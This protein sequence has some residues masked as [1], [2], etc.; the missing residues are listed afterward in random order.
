VQQSGTVILLHLLKHGNPAFRYHSNEGRTETGL[1]NSAMN[2]NRILSID[3][4]RSGTSRADVEIRPGNGTA[5][6]PRGITPAFKQRSNAL[7]IAGNAD[8]VALDGRII[9]AL[10]P[11]SNSLSPQ[12]MP[13][14]IFLIR[15]TG[16]RAGHLD[17]IIRTE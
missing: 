4:L 6:Q 8:L 15:Q 1:Y 14:G 11:G 13:R 2:A 3:E 9:R 17:A 7:E 5:A 16:S 10:H 12:S